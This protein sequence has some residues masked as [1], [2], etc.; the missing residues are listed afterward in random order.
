MPIKFRCP[1][2]GQKLRIARRKAGSVVPCPKCNYP[3]SVPHEDQ[4]DDA[5]AR[6]VGVTRR[7]GGR[8][9]AS[10]VCGRR[11][12]RPT[13]GGAFGPR[14]PGG[15]VRRPNGGGIGGWGGGS[16]QGGEGGRKP[17][18]R[19]AGGQGRAGRR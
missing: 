15:G 16:G 3:A 10:P 14:S 7:G 12:G 8:W 11:W 2:C 4:P 9:G 18:G 6:G 19:G 13:G 1:S 5:A 17:Q